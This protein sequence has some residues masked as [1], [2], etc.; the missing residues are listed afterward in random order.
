MGELMQPGLRSLVHLSLL[1]F[2]L[3]TVFS[4]SFEHQYSRTALF[5]FPVEPALL[6]PLVHPQL[7]LDLDANGHAWVSIVSSYIT[8]LRLGVLPVCQGYWQK[9]NKPLGSCPLEIQ[10]RTHVRLP[11]FTFGNNCGL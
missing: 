10:V 8:K 9:Y 3:P 11:P 1:G 6:R 5:N 4:I 2:L 7:Q